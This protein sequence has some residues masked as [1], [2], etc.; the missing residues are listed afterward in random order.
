MLVMLF[1]AAASLFGERTQERSPHG[2]KKPNFK[3]RCLS[4]KTKQKLFRTLKKALSPILFPLLQSLFFK[5]FFYLY[6]FF[7]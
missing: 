7:F 2:Q 6:L 3:S 1:D 4:C 5:V